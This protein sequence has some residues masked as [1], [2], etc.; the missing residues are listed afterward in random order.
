MCIFPRLMENNGMNW[1]RVATP[2]QIEHSSNIDCSYLSHNWPGWRGNS[3]YWLITNLKKSTFFNVLLNFLW[4]KF[5]Y[6]HIFWM[7][8]IFPILY[9]LRI[10]QQFVCCYSEMTW[11]NNEQIPYWIIIL[12]ELVSIKVSVVLVH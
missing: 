12:W 3:I 11:S 8:S 2:D 9:W 4:I 5:T 1:T 7:K 10:S 6:H